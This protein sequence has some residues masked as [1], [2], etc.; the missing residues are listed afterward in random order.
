MFSQLPTDNRELNWF[1]LTEAIAQ[2]FEA[3]YQ[4]KR[5]DLPDEVQALP[6]FLDWQSGKL[7][8][9]VTSKFWELA[10]PKKTSIALISAVA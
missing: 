8:N 9:R 2:R 7:Q 5:P 6:I 1:T 3:E 10:Q 4:N